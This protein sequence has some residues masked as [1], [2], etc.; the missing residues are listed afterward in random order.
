MLRS[1]VGSE[2][3]IRDSG[4]TVY[5]G[6]DGSVT[7]WQQITNPYTGV[8]AHVPNIGLV[9]ALLPDGQSIAADAATTNT[10]NVTYAGGGNQDS[11]GTPGAHWGGGTDNSAANETA[12][13][14]S[15]V[16]DDDFWNA[17]ESG[18]SGDDSWQNDGD[19]TN[20]LG[21]AGYGFTSIADMF[22]G[23]GPGQLGA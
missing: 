10:G 22:D 20:D 2:M 9:G 12:L 23:G 17:F 7:P 4:G 5:T 13:I 6:P 14:Q 8:G 11:S 3:C 21:N 15:G 18:Q 16:S 19:P 1:L